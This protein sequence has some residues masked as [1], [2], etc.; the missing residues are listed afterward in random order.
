[1]SYSFSALRNFGQ[2]VGQ[3]AYSPPTV[4]IRLCLFLY[5]RDWFGDE[6]I[7]QR[8]AVRIWYLN[9]EKNSHL[10]ELLNFKK[11]GRSHIYNLQGIC[12]RSEREKEEA[13]SSNPGCD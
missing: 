1:M 6:H 4:E 2:T 10:V 11:A 8:R 12:L 3:G 5:N 7:T 9:R 13:L